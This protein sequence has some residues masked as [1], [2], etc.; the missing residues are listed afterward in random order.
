MEGPGQSKGH[1]AGDKSDPRR[2]KPGQIVYLDA[3]FNEEAFD[4][5]GLCLL[6]K[7]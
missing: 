2:R 1:S 4:V 7:Y 3:G 5:F 6:G